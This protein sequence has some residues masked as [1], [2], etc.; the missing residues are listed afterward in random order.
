MNKSGFTLA[1]VLITLG[2][3][4]VV[5]AIT[6]PALLSNIQSYVRNK[7]VANIQQKFSK[8]TD[9]ML[10][11]D[12]MNDYDST[13]SFV[14]TL[15]N[16]LK[17]A[18]ICSN[19]NL[20]ACWPTDT[21]ILNTDKEWDISKT[22][23]GKNLK[24]KNDD[25]NEWDDT[26]GLI[27]ADGTPFIISYNK[28]CNMEQTTTPSWS[29]AKSSS[30]NC[31]AGIFDW[32]GEKK[33][34]KFGLDTSGKTDVIPFNAKGLG[35]ACAIEAGG[36][37]FG[38]FFE[39]EAL[40]ASECD[41]LKAQGKVKWCYSDCKS[42]P[43]YCGP[44]AL[45]YWAGA[46][47]QCGGLDKMPSDTDLISLYD[48]LKKGDYTSNTQALGLPASFSFWSTK[49]MGFG[50]ASARVFA[51]SDTQFWA[52]DRYTSGIWAVCLGD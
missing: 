7:R 21:V 13:M 30:T 35:S 52:Y 48:E 51:P 26:V 40:T 4:G 46:I 15:K 27:T 3:I 45:D 10:S 36:K 6:M 22:T 50:G 25:N 2:I 18:K 41:V 9:K 24:M 16:H 34:N 44:S 28:K 32:N 47:K 19:G 20:R 31:V 33:P 43:R 37:C 12:G 17:I 23:T 29:E 5:A 38:T 14:N 1:E 39:P 11:L 8:A 42:S 49:E